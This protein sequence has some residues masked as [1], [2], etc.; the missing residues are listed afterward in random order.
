MNKKVKVL[1]SVLAL[2]GAATSAMAKT[3]NIIYF[4]TIPQ[5]EKY[6]PSSD[7]LGFKA[8]VP[9]SP[10]TAGY[11]TGK[12]NAHKFLGELAT[13]KPQQLTSTGYI[14]GAKF[15]EGNIIG[16]TSYGALIHV[17][18][19][20][21]IEISCFYTYPTRVGTES[22]TLFGSNYKPGV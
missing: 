15:S 8:N 6:C 11:V 12:K 9:G 3:P 22:V 10:T 7:Q 20:K 1:V 2:L 4:Q 16:H 17:P 21:T 13:D 18:D 14:Q 19:G 5:A